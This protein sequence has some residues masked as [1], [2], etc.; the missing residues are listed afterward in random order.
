MA[1]NDERASTTSITEAISGTGDGDGKRSFRLNAI[2]AGF[3]YSAPVN[4]DDNP[5]QNCNELLD[6]FTEASGKIAIAEYLISCER[7]ESGKKHFHAYIKWERRVD[8]SSSTHFD[9]KGIHPNIKTGIKKAWENYVAKDGDYITNYYIPK[10]TKYTEALK[11]STVAEA[12]SIIA[13]HHPRDYVLNRSRIAENLES[14]HRSLTTPTTTSL[15]CQWSEY[16][17]SVRERILT[18]W[19]ERTIVLSGPTC[20]GKT[21]LALSMGTSPLLVSHLD[22]L[23]SIPAGTSHLVLDDMFLGHLP[24]STVLHLTDLEHPRD[25][26]VRYSVATLPS[27]LP[28][29]LTTNL[30]E[31]LGN[32]YGVLRQ[33]DP[34][35]KRRLEW[36]DINMCLFNKP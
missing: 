32:D 27:G 13:T 26:H 1:K 3:T 4:A 7:H 10:V 35:I 18:S 24:R 21:S 6:F 23:K 36:I 16:G 22:R 25:I 20:L 8:Y 12:L 9:F 2:K 14:H 19:T 33:E 17:D 30:T 11:A 29:I 5:I 31:F 15:H 28:R 34:A